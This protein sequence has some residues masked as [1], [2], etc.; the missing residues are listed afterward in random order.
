M[1]LVLDLRFRQGGAT[2]YRPINRFFAAVYEPFIDKF[3]KSSQDDGLVTGVHGAIF[4]IPVGKHTEALELTS[5]L[6]D[7]AF[8][9]LLAGTS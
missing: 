8:G 1:G 7:K 9:K 6:F 2:G 4:T 3:S 5:L